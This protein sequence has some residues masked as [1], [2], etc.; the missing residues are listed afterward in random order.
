MLLLVANRFHNMLGQGEASGQ[1]GS[2]LDEDDYKSIFV[3]YGKSC[4]F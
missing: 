3:V 4:T 2:V 1:S